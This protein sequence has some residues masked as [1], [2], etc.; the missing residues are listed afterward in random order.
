[1]DSCW[2]ADLVA[3]VAA[4]GENADVVDVA[5][6]QHKRATLV[7]VNFMMDIMNDKNCF[8]DVIDSTLRLV[9]MYS[10]RGTMRCV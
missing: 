6:V 9:C 3:D 1:M 4:S 10:Q 5:T 2:D 7:Q 8:C